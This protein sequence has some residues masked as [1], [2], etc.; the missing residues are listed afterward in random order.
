MQILSLHA[1][2]IAS[3]GSKILKKLHMVKLQKSLPQSS[4]QTTFPPGCVQAWLA[5]NLFLIHDG[6]REQQLTLMRSRYVI[7]KLP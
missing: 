1:L 4:T 7:E 6:G 2:L 5:R 3:A